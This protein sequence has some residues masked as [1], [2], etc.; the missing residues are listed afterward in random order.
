MQMNQNSHGFCLRGSASDVL[1]NGGTHHFAKIW[2][3]PLTRRQ[4]GD[5]FVSLQLATMVLS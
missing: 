1:R 5:G 4:Y 2:V 3:L